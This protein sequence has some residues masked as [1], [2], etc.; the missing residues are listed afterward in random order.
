MCLQEVE[1]DWRHDCDSNQGLAVFQNINLPRRQ[2]AM[3]TAG[4]IIITVVAWLR[5]AEH[6]TTTLSRSPSYLNAA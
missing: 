1:G 3:L 5:P 4:A 2:T 6:P